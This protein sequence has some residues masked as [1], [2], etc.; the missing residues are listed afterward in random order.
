MFEDYD[1][2]DLTWD[3]WA[4]AQ[5]RACHQYNWNVPVYINDETYKI[6]EQNPSQRDFLNL[7]HNVI[8]AYK[9]DELPFDIKSHM[10]VVNPKF[11]D[12]VRTRL[13]VAFYIYDEVQCNIKVR[14]KDVKAIL[15]R[16]T[17]QRKRYEALHNAKDHIAKLLADKPEKKVFEVDRNIMHIFTS[18]DWSVVL[19]IQNWCGRLLDKFDSLDKITVDEILRLK[20]ERGTSV[21]EYT[22]FVRGDI[23]AFIK[24]VIE[25]DKSI[26]KIMSTKPIIK[27]RGLRETQRDFKKYKW[28]ALNVYLFDR[29]VT[30]GKQELSDQE[31]KNIKN[32]WD[33]LVIPKVLEVKPDFQHD[34]LPITTKKIKIVE[35]EEIVDWVWKDP[36]EDFRK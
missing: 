5:F 11:W 27:G 36:M 35:D 15:D 7:L 29:A 6:V 3:N 23:L 31:L 28:S 8:E 21:Y 4:N 24:D 17:S 12:E 1:R 16:F 25:K 2:N 19:T 26:S 34:F 10:E 32:N 13:A 30:D 18:T 14:K 20:E 33:G 22:D 9:K